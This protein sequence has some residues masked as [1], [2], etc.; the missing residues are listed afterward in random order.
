MEGYIKSID[1]RK[2]R[3]KV[4]LNLMGEQRTVELSI[5]MVQTA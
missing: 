1:K 3:V 4:V 5:R 2:G